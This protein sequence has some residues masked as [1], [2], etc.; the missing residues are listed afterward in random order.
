MTLFRKVLN[1]WVIAGLTLFF[2]S[3]TAWAES[4]VPDPGNFFAATPAFDP[5][6]PGTK[7]S[8]TLSI[9]YVFTSDAA[10]L[11]P[12]EPLGNG[13]R[14]SNMFVVISLQHGNEITPYNSDFRA[15]TSTNPI[16]NKG[17]TPSFCFLGEPQQIAF[18]VEMLRTR[19]VP[20]LYTPCVRR[21][22]NPAPGD[23][24]PAS[25]PDF[26]IKAVSNMQSSGHGSLRSDIT[27][28]VRD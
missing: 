24:T 18:V 26:R 21:P 22:A 27:I 5:N 3:P 7:Y 1:S 25:C 2:A 13:I 15:N 19:V 23:I 10:C 14:I 9:A 12:A 17:E 8:G 4:A 11:P 16:L 28:A 6:A 20:S